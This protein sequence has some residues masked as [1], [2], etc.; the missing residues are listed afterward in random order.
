MPA[1]LLDDR[2]V[3]RLTG[4]ESSSFLQGLVSNAVDRIPD[5][6]SRFAA[7]LS[8]Q[9]KILCDFFVAQPCGAPPAELYVDCPGARLEDLVARLQ[10]YRLRAKVAIDDV[11]RAFAIAAEWSLAEERPLRPFRYDDPRH[12]RAGVRWLL[13]RESP[14]QFDAGFEDYEAHRIALCLPK[15]DA[16][17]LYGDAF[18]HEANMDR[19]NGLDF[20]KGCYIG[21]EVVSRMQ[22][23][24]TVR[25]RVVRV[26]FE[27]PPPPVSTEVRAGE[28]LL[29]R[30]GAG[31]AGQGLA[32]LRTDR[33]E[34]AVSAGV[35]VRAGSAELR[36]LAPNEPT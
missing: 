23:R 24:G 14:A 7:L 21:Q 11:S 27:G 18:P 2:G 32:M 29:G 33:L 34:E 31:V 4:E 17:F 1:A 28:V 20:R 3:I 5:G 22:H 8:P 35:P 16:D 9:G 15:G 25:N 12:P 10:R 36:L 19:L 13:R 30:M 26:N 6:E